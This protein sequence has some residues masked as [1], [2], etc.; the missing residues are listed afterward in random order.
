MSDSLLKVPTVMSWAVSKSGGDNP[1]VD[2]C[3]ASSSNDLVTDLGYPENSTL[4]AGMSKCYDQGN[5]LWYR[6]SIRREN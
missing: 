3:Y 1:Q 2:C 5:T 6:D 4:N